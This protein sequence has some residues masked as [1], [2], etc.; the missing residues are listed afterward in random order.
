MVDRCKRHR[1]FRSPTNRFLHTGSED[2]EPFQSPA[3]QLYRVQAAE[4]KIM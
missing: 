4:S 3:S 1:E 2:F